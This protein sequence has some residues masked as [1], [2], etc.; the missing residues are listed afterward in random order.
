MAFAP[1]SPF[2]VDGLTKYLSM[3][4]Y[5]L[6]NFAIYTFADLGIADYFIDGK[7]D[8]GLTIEE[9]LSDNR[10]QWKSDL[11]DRVLRACI[12]AGLVKLV[13]DDKH[14]ILTESGMMMTSDH[15]SHV[16]HHV[17]FIFGP[18]FTGASQQLP[19]LISGEIKDRYWS[20]IRWFR[21]LCINGAT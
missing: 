10:K 5:Q 18:I 9:I 1:V 8:H 16:R 11:L 15:L 19:A 14:F 6:I 20:Y 21:F 3:A 12:Y 17:R 7:L 13:N 4:Y 2:S